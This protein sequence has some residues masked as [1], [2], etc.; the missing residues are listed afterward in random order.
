MDHERIRIGST[1]LTRRGEL[2]LVGTGLFLVLVIMS[3][4]GGLEL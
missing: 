3:I 2:T 4:V 1:T